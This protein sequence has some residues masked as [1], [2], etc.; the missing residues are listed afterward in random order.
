L[1]IV[2]LP[3]LALFV[4]LLGFF[5]YQ[6]TI[7][8][9]PPGEAFARAVA[10]S[11]GIP[12]ASLI[13]TALWEAAPFALLAAYVLSAEAEAGRKR[14]WAILACG[15]AVIAAA[16]LGT[17]FTLWSVPFGTALALL[18]VSAGLMILR[19]GDIKDLLRQQ[20]AGA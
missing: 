14:R 5:L 17:Y 6:W 1:T 15:A 16:E 3:L 2:L 12:A 4:P 9:L 13:V 20:T 19:A 11:T 18:V 10:L 8:M 7:S